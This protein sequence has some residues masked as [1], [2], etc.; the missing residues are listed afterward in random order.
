MEITHIRSLPPLLR[1]RGALL[2]ETASD[3]YGKSAA[4]GRSEVVSRNSDT[5]PFAESLFTKTNF[6]DGSQHPSFLLLLSCVG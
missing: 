4:H 1:V 3:V 2:G 6:C 5:L